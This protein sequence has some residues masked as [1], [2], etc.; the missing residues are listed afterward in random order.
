MGVRLLLRIDVMAP[1]RKAS[2]TRNVSAAIAI[3][4]GRILAKR[5]VDLWVEETG[6]W[7]LARLSL[8]RR[9]VPDFAIVSKTDGNATL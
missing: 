8:G 5:T 2:T 6:S 1:F 4:P 7:F 9:I 3:A